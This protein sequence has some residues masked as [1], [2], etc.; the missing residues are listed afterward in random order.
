MSAK[1]IKSSNW[2]FSVVVLFPIYPYKR[3]TENKD[4]KQFWE[5]H[6]NEYLNFILVFLTISNIPFY[7]LNFLLNSLSL[8]SLTSVIFSR[9]LQ[10][11]SFF[12]YLWNLIE[13]NKIILIQCFIY[14]F[15]SNRFI[16]FELIKMIS[17]FVFR[18][19]IQ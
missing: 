13:I 12:L 5:E 7:P 11:S 1:W 8:H 17:I 3:N 9:I 19:S 10:F 16:Q 6:M 18:F 2:K 15:L 4:N 14:D